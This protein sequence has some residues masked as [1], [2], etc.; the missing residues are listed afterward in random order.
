[1]K[2]IC[3]LVIV[4]ALL[5]GL[6]SCGVKKPSEIPSTN[7]SSNESIQSQT[8]SLQS[9]TGNTQSQSGSTQSQSG[10]TQ[11]QTGNTSSKNSKTPGKLLDLKGRT[12]T[13]SA[14]WPEPKKGTD[15]A[16]NRYWIQKEAVEKR[17]NCKINYIYKNLNQIEQEI[18]PSILS[19]S[20]IADVFWIQQNTLVPKIRKKIIYPISD[21]N[22]FDVN[23]SRF[24]VDATKFSTLYG[25]TYGVVNNQTNF[26]Y[27]LLYNKTYFKQQGL[28]D[29]VTLQTAGKLSWDKLAEIAKQAT[30][31]G[32][33]GLAP[34]ES[35]ELMSVCMMRANGGGIVTVDKNTNFSCVIN[36]PQNAYALNFYKKMK[37]EDKS[38]LELKGGYL[39][40]AEQFE[41][42]KAAMLFASGYMNKDIADKS[43]FELGAV[44]FPSGP[45]AT[46]P[47]FI[48]C[49]SYSLQVMAST[50]KNPEEVASVWFEM[51][52]NTS[53]FTWEERLSDIFT[54]KN[55]MQSFKT[56]HNLLLQGKY[57]QDYGTTV[58]EFYGTVNMFAKF[59]QMSTGEISVAQGLESLEGVI[60]QSIKDQTK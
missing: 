55:S 35:D 57:I 5:I 48:D 46:L 53:P 16:A 4:L 39:Y 45:N 36:S 29:L 18:V 49:S 15:D 26:L 33:A 2:K 25:K 32:V 54:D 12:I 52:K 47:Y 8:E 22:N 30:K 42:G 7:S 13:F 10:S 28:E 19:G 9:Q 51:S 43:K 1:M 37:M 44:I 21:L 56:Y 23:D 60:K 27:M 17:F 6:F 14:F 40:P 20:P 58:A 31:N 24:M 3:S 11:S 38:I 41:Q 34:V 50:T 59:R